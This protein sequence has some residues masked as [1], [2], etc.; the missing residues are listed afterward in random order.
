MNL[1]I[2]SSGAVSL[3]R[4]CFF[5][6]R[7]LP[8][9]TPHAILG[10]FLA[11][12]G[13]EESQET[14]KR[15]IP[16]QQAT[17]DHRQQPIL[18]FFSQEQGVSF[19]DAVRES[20]AFFEVLKISP[21]LYGKFVDDELG[22]VS[23]KTCRTTSLGLASGCK[24]GLGTFLVGDAGVLNFGPQISPVGNCS[25]FGLAGRGEKIVIQQHEDQD[26]L[27]YRCRL[28]A[29]SSRETGF[30]HLKDSGYSALWIFGE[31]QLKT[32]EM[33]F[34]GRI[35]GCRSL[36]GLIFALFAKG[37]SCLVSGSHKLQPRSLD[38]YQGPLE[39][40]EFI[41]EDSSVCCDF[42]Q[43]ADQME[44]I[45]LAGDQSFW[46][47]DFLVAFRLTCPMISLHL[48]ERN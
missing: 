34:K 15:M 44:V 16:F 17:L 25:G 24:S 26:L 7:G 23:K 19:A 36:N 33:L 31:L 2:F 11:Q 38:R 6:W 12:I 39:L 40:L 1:E 30:A 10:N 29:P 3:Y 4:R 28:A 5:P 20:S 13:D 8:Y 42:S 46:G 45:P 41:G 37:K 48:Y 21:E 43:G 22:I 27:S 14:A 35:E 47:A 32:T 9:P 18:S